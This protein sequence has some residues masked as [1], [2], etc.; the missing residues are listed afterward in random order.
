MKAVTHVAQMVRQAELITLIEWIFRELHDYLNC[1]DEEIN[2][3]S[4]LL[5][6]PYRELA[7]QTYHPNIHH[8]HQGPE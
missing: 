7:Q 2:R 1:E 5:S 8:M 3:N 4:N 6:A